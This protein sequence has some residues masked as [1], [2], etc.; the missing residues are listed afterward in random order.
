MK[1]FK[2][3]EVIC[4]L[5]SALKSNMAAISMTCW[6]FSTILV[7]FSNL[8]QFKY[9]TLHQCNVRFIIFPPHTLSSLSS[10]IN[11]VLVVPLYVIT[12]TLVRTFLQHQLSFHSY[13]LWEN[14]DQTVHQTQLSVLHNWHFIPMHAICLGKPLV[15][16]IPLC[17]ITTNCC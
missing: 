13:C 1:C 11:L 10:E 4:T 14:L 5:V 9:S 12:R 15:L 2:I 6:H 17:L 16:P 8:Y 3:I 7:L